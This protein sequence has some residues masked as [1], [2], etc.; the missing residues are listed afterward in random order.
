MKKGNDFC[1]QLP[2]EQRRAIWEYT[3]N[4]WYKNINNTLR[5]PSTSQFDPG[6]LERTSQIHAGLSQASLPCE[7]TVH[8]GTRCDFLD[9]YATVRKMFGSES[10]CR[11][12]GL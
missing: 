10:C 12:A 5:H 8:R 4:E 3:Q 2:A 6:N 11:N 9:K 1:M 7:C